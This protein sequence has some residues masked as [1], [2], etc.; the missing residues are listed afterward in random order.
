MC[1]LAGVEGGDGSAAATNKMLGKKRGT[2][3][4][5]QCG[6]ECP[7]FPRPG[8][9]A[10]GGLPRPC[11]LFPSA[12]S[13]RFATA[14]PGQRAGSR[15]LAQSCFLGPKHDCPAVGSP[16]GGIPYRSLSAGVGSHR[17][18]RPAP[19]FRAR[20]VPGAARRA[21]YGGK[22]KKKPCGCPLPFTN[23]VTRGWPLRSLT[24]STAAART[25]SEPLLIPG[26]AHHVGSGAR[27]GPAE[28]SAGCNCAALP[29]ASRAEPPAMTPQG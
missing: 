24:A 21:L 23:T 28:S 12:P 17:H 25:G 16:S 7:P 1:F 13:P 3:V 5:L 29:S 20:C 9:A 19:R 6:R 4:T 2:A 26:V 11:C 10:P 14:V 22:W 27:L 8:V 18:G 15:P